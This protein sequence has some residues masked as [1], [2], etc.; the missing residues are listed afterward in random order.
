MKNLLQLYQKLCKEPLVRQPTIVKDI[1]FLPPKDMFELLEFLENGCLD[2]T[3]TDDPEIE[4]LP[5]GANYA[6]VI[7][8]EKAFKNRLWHTNIIA[9]EGNK[10]VL[11]A[12]ASPDFNGKLRIEIPYNE[13]TKQY[14]KEFEAYI[15]IHN[16]IADKFF[17]EIGIP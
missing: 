17:E 9:A 6:I 4:T 16:N 3:I 2:Y 11:E 1:T 15:F 8:Y 10:L 7:P 12:Y 5:I 14:P 13:A